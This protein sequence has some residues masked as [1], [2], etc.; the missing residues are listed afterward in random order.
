LTKGLYLSSPTNL[1][2]DSEARGCP[3]LNAVRPFSAKAKS[4]NWTAEGKRINRSGLVRGFD[5]VWG[6]GKGGGEEKRG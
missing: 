4:K 5:E 1:M 2:K 6:L 3:S